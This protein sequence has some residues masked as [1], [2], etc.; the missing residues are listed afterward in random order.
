MKCKGCGQEFDNLNVLT[1]HKPD[2][3]GTIDKPISKKP[4]IPLDLCPEEV[5]LYAMGHTVGLKVTGVLTP[6]GIEVQE[7][8][9]I[10]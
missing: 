9:L 7:V 1:K 4:F 2:C 8:T 5:K 10:R 3:T 6:K